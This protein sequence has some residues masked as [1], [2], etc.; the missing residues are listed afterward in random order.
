[1][2]PTSTDD[3][4]LR[5]AGPLRHGAAHGGLADRARRVIDA[6]AMKD[7]TAISALVAV[8]AALAAIVG[9]MA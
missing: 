5:R 4:R 7:W 8:I 3:G 6:A 2:G 9:V 1:M